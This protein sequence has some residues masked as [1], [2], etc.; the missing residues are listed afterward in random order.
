VRALRWASRVSV[1]GPLGPGRGAAV[2]TWLRTVGLFAITVLLVEYVVLP[3]VL[4]TRGDLHLFL[5]ASPV[6]LSMALALEAASLVSY[7]VLTRLVLPEGS[8]PPFV[9]QLRIDLTGLGV[10]HI[11]P[12][13]G[14]TAAALRYRLLTEQGVPAEDA[15]STTAVESA[16][17]AIGLVG[18]FLA[19]LVLMGPRL[20]SRPGYV[21]A[22][23]AA[24]CALAAVGVGIHQIGV[25]VPASRS[26]E[27]RRR[28]ARVLEGRRGHGAARVRRLARRGVRA[29]R[30]TA[31]RVAALVRDPRARTAVFTSAVCNWVFDAASLWLCLRCYGVSVGPGALLAAYGA[32]NLLALLPVTPGGLGIVEGVLVPALTGL[33]GVAVG[34]VTLG[35]LTWRLLEFW[36]PIPVAAFTYLSLRLFPARAAGR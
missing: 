23:L 4:S 12:G 5:D 35:V 27:A 1:G 18:T 36:I 28:R 15:A 31:R 2:W 17:A 9:D 20:D 25:A 24:A 22:G 8:R 33:G 34:P 26:D 10:S 29:T 13:G 6:L 11:V 14:A 3:R 21:A 32:A 16:V 30:A 7:T 19:G